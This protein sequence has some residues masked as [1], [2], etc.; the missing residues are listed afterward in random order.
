MITCKDI[1]I[2][3]CTYCLWNTR[4]DILLYT[5][6]ITIWNSMIRVNSDSLAAIKYQ[7][8]AQFKP[9]DLMYLRVIVKHFY[10]EHLATYDKMTLLI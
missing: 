5:C 2:E 9:G 10:P 1:D 3:L 8:T 6:L 4:S 7:L